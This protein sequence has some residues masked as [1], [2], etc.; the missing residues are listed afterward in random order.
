M[1]CVCGLIVRK[2]SVTCRSRGRSVRLYALTFSLRQNEMKPMCNLPGTST[3][4]LWTKN[5]RLW[6]SR[7][8]DYVCCRE[9]CN[10][11]PPICHVVIWSGTRERERNQENWFCFF[12]LQS[13]IC[14]IRYRTECGQVCASNMHKLFLFIL[15]LPTFDTHT[16]SVW[17]PI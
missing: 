7:V 1:S 10:T 11:P 17:R 16:A 3:K 13:S 6:Q 15:N 8:D 2:G 9:L 12:F 5:L 4:N 14:C